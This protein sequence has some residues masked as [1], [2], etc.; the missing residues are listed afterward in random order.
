MTTPSMRP[1][2]PQPTRLATEGT[3]T[4]RPVVADVLSVAETDVVSVSAADA[5][6]P[7]LPTP[8]GQSALL[9]RAACI[10]ATGALR[11]VRAGTSQEAT[12]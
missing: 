1:P 5:S 12:P 7:A 11:A 8:G 3:P 6:S 10:L 2:L 9:Q 4:T